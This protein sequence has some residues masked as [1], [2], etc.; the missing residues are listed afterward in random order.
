MTLDQILLLGSIIVPALSSALLF[1]GIGGGDYWAKKLAY[2]GFG[3]PFIAGI[4]LFFNFD[5]SNMRQVQPHRP[6]QIKGK[7][8]RLVLDEK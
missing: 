1:A 8:P 2:I 6:W 7:K 4:V 5:G 3:F